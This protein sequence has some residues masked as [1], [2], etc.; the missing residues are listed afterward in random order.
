MRSVMRS[1]AVG[2]VAVIGSLVLIAHAAGPSM[3][4]AAAA[5]GQ[6][7][8]PPSLAALRMPSGTQ[9]VLELKDLTLLRRGVYRFRVTYAKAPGAKKQDKPDGLTV[10]YVTQWF[11]PSAKDPAQPPAFVTRWQ[12]RAKMGEQLAKLERAGV[13]VQFGGQSEP[14]RDGAVIDLSLTQLAGG[15]EAMASG[16]IIQELRRPNPGFLGLVLTSRGAPISN[17]TWVPLSFNLGPEDKSRF[18][19][20]TVE[21][22]AP[23]TRPA[24]AAATENKPDALVLDSALPAGVSSHSG[25]VKG[26]AFSPDGSLLASWGSNELKLWDLPSGRLHATLSE[27]SVETAAFS[28]DGSLIFTGGYAKAVTV[29]TVPDGRFKARLMGFNGEYVGVSALAAT[30]NGLLVATEGS[31]EAFAFFSLPEFTW[32][33]TLGGDT[34]VF[35]RTII[36]PD[37]KHL[38]GGG[39]PVGN[40]GLWSISDGRLAR[41]FKSEAVHLAFSPDGGLLAS[42]RDGRVVVW[43]VPAGEVAAELQVQGAKGMGLGD[44]VAFS[45]DGKILATAAADYQVEVF[46]VAT[47]KSEAHFVG[48][49]SIGDPGVLAISPDGTLLAGGTG[50]GLVVIW[51]LRGEKRR[52]VLVD[53][54]LAKK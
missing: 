51:E 24:G 40:V 15:K 7:A 23:R 2:V 34:Q 13:S 19:V 47:W 28:R 14:D 32:R 41:T 10:F 11:R 25:T 27:D 42:V 49:R 4:Q 1:L 54:A 16:K 22:Y 35:G 39:L 3:N 48:N 36:S 17:F 18:S 44:A 33:A 38:A 12:D 26:L 37:G 21:P 9:L 5:T 20:D 52:L 50:Q 43:T 30:G 45:P 53:P 31:N 46:S 8:I 6:P 29:R